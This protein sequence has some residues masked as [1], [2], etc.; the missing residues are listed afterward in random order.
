MRA[1][2]HRGN[3]CGPSP[4]S[5][6]N[7]RQIEYVIKYGYDVEVDVMYIDKKMYLGHDVP[8]WEISIEWLYNLSDKLWVHCKNLQAM[9]ILKG[10]PKINFFSHNIDD[11]VLTSKGNIWTYPLKDTCR[12][13]VIV[14]NTEDQTRYYARKDIFGI[15]TDW[16]QLV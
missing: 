8:M 6:N 13:S 15:C 3:L 14:C 5:E 2:S 9:Y 4:K 16:P 12:D 7:I 11:Y 1:I 10:Y